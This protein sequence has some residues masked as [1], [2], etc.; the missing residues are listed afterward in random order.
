M[1]G[2]SK[3]KGREAEKGLRNKEKDT[4]G[5]V[6]VSKLGSDYGISVH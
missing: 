4:L 6:N 3:C 5:F 2:Y 1:S